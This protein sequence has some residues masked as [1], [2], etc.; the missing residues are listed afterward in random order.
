MSL[1]NPAHN[2]IKKQIR[3]HIGDFVFRRVLRNYVWAPVF[4][5]KISEDGTSH[6]FVMNHQSLKYPP[7][8]KNDQFEFC[9]KFVTMTETRI[10]RRND[11]FSDESI[12]VPSENFSN[13]DPVS[14][15]LVR[16]L[17]EN[18]PLPRPAQKGAS[19]DLICGH[20]SRSKEGKPYYS[21]WF[22]CS[23]Q[24]LRLWTLLMHD[25]H[26]SFYSYGKTDQAQR[27]KL[28]SGNRLRPN[29]YEAFRFANPDGDHSSMFNIYRT[30]LAPLAYIHIYNAIATIAR[31]GEL[32]TR[33][34]V[35]NNLRGP[36]IDTWHLPENFAHKFLLYWMPRIQLEKDI[37]TPPTRVETLD[38]I[39][40]MG[41][42]SFKEEGKFPNENYK[43][44]LGKSWYEMTLEDE[45]E[46]GSWA[47][48]EINK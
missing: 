48:A 11:E 10:M 12:V 36:Q 2:H 35:P 31:W 33:D 27:R 6:P 26:S 46:E 9:P 41:N 7:G 21:S 8:S 25:T 24:F 20:V 40:R 1:S 37:I 15:K 19:S 5:L 13:F 39:N 23:E 22:L 29:S 47:Y 32:P 4:V 43:K 44:Y 38:D 16:D 42:M 34:N 28:I 30:E 17:N 14:L 3:N 45:K 18:V